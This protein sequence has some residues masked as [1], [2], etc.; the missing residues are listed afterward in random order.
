MKLVIL[1]PLGVEKESLLKIA[2][3][4]L[5]NAAEIIYYD[6]KTTDTEELIRRGADADIVICSIYRYGS[7]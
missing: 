6:T 2:E 3:N 4:A 5:S 7:Y 1:E